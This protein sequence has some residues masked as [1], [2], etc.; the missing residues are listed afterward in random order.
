MFTAAQLV[1]HAFGDYVVQS[2]WMATAKTK[3]ST[4][5][6]AHV[7]TYTLFFVPLAWDSGLQLS[8]LRWKALLFIAA[9]H[10]VIDRWRLARYVCWA[11]NFLAPKHIEVLHP[12]GHS[13]AGQ[14]AGLIRNAPWSE[15]SGTGYDRAKPAWMAVWLMIIADNCFHVVCN[16]VALTWL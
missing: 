15:C 4:A 9:T 12:E 2:D 10:F 11:K 7:L 3:K 14:V 5:A 16:A 6:L 13:Q 1:A 8:T